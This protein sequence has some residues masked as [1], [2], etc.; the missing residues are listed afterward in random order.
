MRLSSWL[1]L[2]VLSGFGVSAGA[3]KIENIRIWPAPDNTRLV[4]DITQPVTYELISLSNPDRL[5][6]DI[7]RSLLST[8]V[9]QLDFSKSPVRA[10][11]SS[12][13]SD[14]KLR[15]V[16]DLA[17]K[18]NHKVFTLAPNASYGHRLVVDLSNYRQTKILT[19][20]AVI[21]PVQ[22]QTTTLNS[23]GFLDSQRDIVIAIDAGHG[24]EDP[25]A[26]GPKYSGRKLR[27]KHVVLGIAKELQ[28]LILNS[29]W[30]L[31]R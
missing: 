29:Q 6:I 23:L 11:R 5:V 14:N 22:P 8:S 19:K 15:L 20:G 2:L 7:D 4:F 13:R 10:I 24:G 12:Q 18:V 31:L 28:A 9:A 30:R 17:Y 3:A 26:L 1:L 27:E 25:G 21:K 16:L